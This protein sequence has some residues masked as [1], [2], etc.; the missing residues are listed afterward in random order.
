MYLRMSTIPS[1]RAAYQ[2][3]GRKNYIMKEEKL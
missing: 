1:F 3:I 2:E